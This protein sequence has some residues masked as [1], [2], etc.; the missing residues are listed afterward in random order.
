V[1]VAAAGTR[2]PAVGALVGDHELVDAVTQGL[3]VLCVRLG[4]ISAII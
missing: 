2:L 1:A 4:S 3:S